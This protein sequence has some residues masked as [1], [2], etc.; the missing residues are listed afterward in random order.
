M[1]FYI[2]SLHFVILGVKK[3]TPE[4]QFGNYEYG[5]ASFRCVLHLYIMHADITQAQRMN[6]DKT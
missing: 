6:D 3:M 4:T 2:E 1:K 5:F